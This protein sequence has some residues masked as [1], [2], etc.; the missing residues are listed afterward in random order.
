MQVRDGGP[1]DKGGTTVGMRHTFG[2]ASGYI[3]KIEPTWFTEEF[4]IR[5]EKKK[6]TPI[7]WHE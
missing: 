5:R 1:K 4:D 3:L 2:Y 6:I 7:F